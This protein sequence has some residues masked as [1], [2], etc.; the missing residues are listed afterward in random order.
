MMRQKEKVHWTFM[1]VV[2]LVGLIA[3]TICLFVPIIWGLITSF[4]GQADFRINVIGL[5]KEWIWN[6]KQVFQQFVIPIFT[7]SGTVHIGMGEML[8]N[9]LLYAIGCAFFSTLIPCIT[10]YLCARYDYFLSKVIYVIVIV[11]MILPI[12]GSLPSEI[13]V[14]RAIGAYDHMWGMWLLKANFLGLY[15]IVFYNQFKSIP[16]AYAEAARID[17]AGNWSILLKIMLPLARNTFLTVMLIRFIEF[18]NDYQTPLI[19]LST[20][21]TISLGVYHMAYTTLNELSTIP[22]RMTAAVIAMVPIMVLF[23]CC[24]KRLLGNLTVGGIKG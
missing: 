11:T 8:T 4:K 24:H 6:Y 23:L 18:W 14:A 22:M 2:L 15:F 9:S 10:S 3:Y 20:K 17:G 16:Q 12:V 5:P 13:R 21:P 1:K 7:D 19:Y